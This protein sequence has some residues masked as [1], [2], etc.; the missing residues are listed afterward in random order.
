MS[1]KLH[2]APSTASGPVA[3]GRKIVEEIGLKLLDMD[4]KS[5]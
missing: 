3:R 1:K 5:E 4:I 2:I